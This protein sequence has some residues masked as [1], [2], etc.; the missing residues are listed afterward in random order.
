MSSTT[1]TFQ[2]SLEIAQTYEERF[3]PSL[4]AEWAPRTLDAADV[5]PGDRVLDV[6]CGTGVVTREAAD[7]TG[8]PSSV[9]GVDLNEAMLT[10][11]RRVRG[12]IEFLQ[13][14]AASLPVPDGAYDAV[15]CQSAFMFFPDRAAAVREMARAAAPGGR[16]VVQVWAALDEQPAW[17]PFV[18]I[19]ARHAGPD[20]VSL[21]GSYWSAGDVD[22]VARLLGDA[23]LEPAGV[24]SHTGT[25]RFPS[26]DAF[27]RTEVDSTPLVQRIDDATYRAILD[28]TAGALAGFVTDEGALLPIR[29]HFVC[30]RKA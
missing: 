24:R 15:V 9:T 25:A 20:A 27:V 2:V 7:R 21:L 28:D 12:D 26:L 5:G 3:V 19:A 4:F 29:G 16:V 30:G 14:D 1:E 17:G 23:G 6:A 8:D 22:A 18:D 13:G 11:A 10:V